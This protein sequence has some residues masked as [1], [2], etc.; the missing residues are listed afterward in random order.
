M[1]ESGGDV[2]DVTQDLRVP[3]DED[4]GDLY[5]HAPCGYLTTLP[6]GTIVRVNETF[7]AWT[8]YDWAADASVIC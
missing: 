2:P 8:G 6:D 7:L 5:E 3:W 4:P 1:T